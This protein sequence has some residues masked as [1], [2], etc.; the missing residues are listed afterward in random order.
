M[1]FPT[2]QFGIFFP[3][4]FIGSW[5]LRPHPRRWKLFMLVA[6][7]IFYGWWDW[8]YCFLLAGVTLANQLFVIGVAEARSAAGKRAWCTGGVT[9]N[10]AVLAYFKYYG[11]FVD[12]VTNGFDRL[13]VH[14]SPPL[15]KV[16]LP[17]G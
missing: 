7:Y 10:I 2:I 4:V 17:I 15:L 1:L 3:L 9:A 14:V 6:S 13:G 16:I 12:S 5:L 8:H 11:F